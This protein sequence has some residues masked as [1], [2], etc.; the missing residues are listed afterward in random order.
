MIFAD[1][2]I[3]LRKKSGW[4]QEEL[5]E[6]LN[7]SRQTISKWEGAQSVPDFK[8][9]IEISEL[10]GVS[11]DYLLK[12]NIETVEAI[13][14]PNF[15]PN[16]KTAESIH[17][18]SMEEANSFIQA[19]DRSSGRFAL[20]V[21]MCII[22]PILLILLECLQ[23]TNRIKLTNNQALGF[24]LIALILLVGVA[25]AI[26]VIEGLH[27]KPY[28]YLEREFIELAYGVDGM[29]NERR[30]K[31]KPTHTKILTTGIIL[32][33][34]SPLPI[35]LSMT[36]GGEDLYYALSV[37][38]SVC[39]L[40]LMVGLGVMMIVQCSII[41]DSFYILSETGEYS[42]AAKKE[43]KRNQNIAAIYW[44]SATAI[45]LAY[46]FITENWSI[47]WIVWPVAGIFY[48]VL[49]AI[50]RMIRKEI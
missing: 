33:V 34:L 37:C 47:S 35:F 3:E 8:R 43:N 45:Y 42:R 10:F 2:L 23:G 12:D 46:S 36:L 40:L 26:F 21:M 29:V 13:A 17:S 49:V 14:V 18:V 39:V 22:S 15:T 31:Y 38:L 11:T 5:A 41:Y 1:K 32:C 25:V 24:G 28:E 9:V 16:E 27:L 30:E 6:K 50:L 19:R 44:G 4:S 20:G 7:V 48:G